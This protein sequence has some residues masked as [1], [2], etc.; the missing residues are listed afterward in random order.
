[1]N[2]QK[3]KIGEPNDV[4]PFNEMSPDEQAKTFQKIADDLA[5]QTPTVIETNRLA[6]TALVAFL[7]L[8]F[9]PPDALWVMGAGLDWVV[10][11]FRK[12]IP[13]YQ[14]LL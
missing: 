5:K 4:H 2:G 7:A 13:Q 6:A 11:G 9:L 10:R 14:V 8:T 3:V 1:M 12:P